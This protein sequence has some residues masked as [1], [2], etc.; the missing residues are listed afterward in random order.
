MQEGRGFTAFRSLGFRGSGG[1]G[2]EEGFRGPLGVW[3]LG[4][5]VRG[6]RAFRGGSG[7]RG[8]GR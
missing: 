3:G 2:P 1:V 5:R 6:F 8:L 4:F 7:F